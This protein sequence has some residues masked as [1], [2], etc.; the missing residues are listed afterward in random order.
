MSA[1]ATAHGGSGDQSQP[2]KLEDGTSDPPWKMT[3]AAGV[4]VVSLAVFFSLVLYLLARTGDS[5][6]TWA[7]S[8]YLLSAIEAIAFAAVGWLF[9]REVHRV[10]AEAAE[11]RA[12][13]AEQDKDQAHRD[14]TAAEKVAAAEQA[15]GG[16]FAATVYSLLSG[17]GSAAE[18]ALPKSPGPRAATAAGSS[19]QL[20][21]LADAAARLYPES[22]L[23]RPPRQ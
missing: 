6:L 17:E 15:K 7:R 1:D 13:V 5:D 4:T 23:G 10:Q 12:D 3:L 16:T 21:A 20:R 9:G 19:P 11:K 8:V 22:T 18:E 2:G 14:R